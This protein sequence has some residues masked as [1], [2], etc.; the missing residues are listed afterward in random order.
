MYLNNILFLSAY[1][2]AYFSK[3]KCIDACIFFSFLVH[4]NP[5]SGY[6]REGDRNSVVSV[7]QNGCDPTRIA[8]LHQNSHTVSEKC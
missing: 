6:N 3:Y 7:M 5:K 8:C 1:F 4:I 2:R